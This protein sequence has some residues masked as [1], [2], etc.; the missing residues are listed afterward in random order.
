[1]SEP[2]EKSTE[3]KPEGTP[4]QN[5]DKNQNTIPETEDAG[6]AAKPAVVLPV[7]HQYSA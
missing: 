7:A 5:D 2:S 6:D 1:M 4:P 3:D